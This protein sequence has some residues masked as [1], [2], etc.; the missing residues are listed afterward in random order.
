AR[1]PIRLGDRLVIHNQP[2]MCSDVILAVQR[3]LFARMNVNLGQAAVDVVFG[4][5]AP[6]DISA[7]CAVSV[8]AAREYLWQIENRVSG[9]AIT[10][11]V[12]SSNFQA[13]GTQRGPG[14]PYGVARPDNTRRVPGNWKRIGIHARISEGRRVSNVVALAFIGEKEKR[15]VLLYGP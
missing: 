8:G 3:V 14:G 2:A 12:E 6:G 5:Q 13:G 11:C 15:L 10:V 1:P 7:G 9:R 4:V